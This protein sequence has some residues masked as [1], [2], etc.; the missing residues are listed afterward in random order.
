V[1]QDKVPIL[2]CERHA[3]LSSTEPQVPT[4]QNLELGMDRVIETP[5]AAN[6]SSS[7]RVVPILPDAC[8]PLIST[9]LPADMCRQV[10]RIR[11][12]RR[13]SP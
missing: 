7:A 1:V 12:R 13:R 2:R 11:I 8:W 9:S 4:V 6:A 10:M 3:E 5:S